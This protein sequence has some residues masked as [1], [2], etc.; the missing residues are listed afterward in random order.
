[1]EPIN[2][3]LLKEV[4]SK[5]I[6]SAKA[7]NTDH[8]WEG[9]AADLPSSSSGYVAGVIKIVVLVTS[10]VSVFTTSDSSGYTTNAHMIRR[11]ADIATLISPMDES[12]VSI[13]GED[14]VQTN[15][16]ESTASNERTVADP[17]VITIEVSDDHDVHVEA[18]IM[19]LNPLNVDLQTVHPNYRL[20]LL[21]DG[22]SQVSLETLRG[23]QEWFIGLTPQ[24][25]FH[26][27]NPND[28]DE[29][30]IVGD[31]DATTKIA[32]R[33][34]ASLSFGIRKPI[35]RRLTISGAATLDYYKTQFSFRVANYRDGLVQQH[36]HRLDA[37]MSMALGY[38]HHSPI[39]HGQFLAEVFARRKVASFANSSYS[40]AISGF[41]LSYLI[42]YKDMQ[43]GPTYGSFF[44][45]M[46]HPTGQVKPNLYGFTV[47]KSLRF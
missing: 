25:S 13:N 33:L 1:M 46:Y 18:N 15:R 10:L 35:T 6:D 28:Y 43:V 45:S 4:L 21:P 31:E 27:M 17:E 5:K 40:K 24:I 22:A 37:G 39:G 36:N 29:I 41:R 47:R 19:R 34:G 23:K 38:A 44:N 8:L 9:I 7:I 42:A 32:D 30:Y 14:L 11:N 2:D 3:Q 26:T 12:N 16:F 20:M